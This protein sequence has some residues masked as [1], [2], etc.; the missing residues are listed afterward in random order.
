MTLGVDTSTDRLPGYTLYS[1]VQL[2]R[3]VKQLFADKG[4]ATEVKF[5]LSEEQQEGKG[6][7]VT[8]VS[9]PDVGSAD[10]GHLRFGAFAKL[11]WGGVV[12][13]WGDES[14]GDN[15]VSIHEMAAGILY[16]VCVAI[17]ECNDG[18]M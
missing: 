15:T 6:N 4:L 9:S 11:V 13:I 17:R 14:L 18:A 7:R 12:Y 16:N 5:G 8:F 3:D 2:Y 1:F 10:S